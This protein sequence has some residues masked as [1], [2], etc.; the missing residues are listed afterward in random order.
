MPLTRS[1]SPPLRAPTPT[2]SS[3][4]CRTATRPWSPGTGRTCPRASASCWPLPGRPWPIPGDDPGRGHLLHRHPH[5][6]A[7]RAGDGCPDGGPHRLCHRPPPV[8]GPQLQLH[9]G[10]RAWRDPGEGRSPGAA[11][12]EGTLL[13]TL[14]RSVPAV[15]T[16]GRGRKAPE[17]GGAPCRRS[18]SGPWPLR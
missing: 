6:T 15:L 5:R 13:S 14:H 3:A 2:P 18:Q 4:A 9:R 17:T 16:P 11:G 8:H 10:H 12:P 7:H 1:A